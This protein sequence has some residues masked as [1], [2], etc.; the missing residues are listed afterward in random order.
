[1]IHRQE[2]EYTDG[3]PY[4][5]IYIFIKYYQINSPKLVTY[6][7]CFFPV[8]QCLRDS[9]ADIVF[10][11]DESVSR[12][13]SGYVAS[14]LSDTINSLDVKEGCIQIG[15]VMYSTEPH[16]ISLLKTETNKTD[17]LHRI[18]KFSPRPGKSNL[19]AAI[20]FTRRKVFDQLAGSRKTQGVEQIA[21]VVTHRSADDSLSDAASLLR[22]AGVTVFAIGIEAAN[23][24]Q[25]TEVVSYPPERNII[26]VAKFSDLPSRTKNFQKKLFNQIQ[27]T[28]YVQSE[29]RILLKTG[30]VFH[31]IQLITPN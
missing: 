14:F 2:K 22:Q 28:L 17:I 8:P 24:T 3:Q 4:N 1:M 30:K 5:I 9:V 21:T 11:V 16:V 31:I 12:E 26:K 23:A 18:Q 27:H 25:L 13:N 6:M 19:G 29:R 7:Y 20:N 15:L 10:V